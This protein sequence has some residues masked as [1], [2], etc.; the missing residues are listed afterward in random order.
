MNDPYKNEKYRPYM[1]GYFVNVD[2]STR[3]HRRPLYPPA[4]KSM[5][6]GEEDLKKIK[7]LTFRPLIMAYN[8]PRFVF[9]YH[10]AGG[11]LGHLMLAVCDSKTK[12]G[13]WLHNFDDIRMIYSDGVIRYE[14][15][16]TAYQD[17]IC[18]IE[19]APSADTI[20]LILRIKVS[21]DATGKTILAF[22]GGAS[23]FYTRKRYDMPEYIYDPIH[24]NKDTIEFNKNSFTLIRAFYP[25]DICMT[26]KYMAPN[27]LHDYT[28]KIR[29]DSQNFDFCGYGTYDEDPYSIYGS[30]RQTD[31]G[32]YKA[33]MG[34]FYQKLDNIKSEMYI[35][36]GMGSG[37]DGSKN[38]LEVSWKS[39]IKRNSDI[40]G[41]IRIKTP[42]Q[43]LDNAMHML[44]FCLEGL[45]GDEAVLHG[46]LSWRTGYLGWR[47]WYGVVCYG[48]E[49]RI[50]KCIDNFI[51]LGLVRNGDDKGAL[52]C[53]YE[54]EPMVYYNMNEVFTDQIRQYFEYTNDIEL[55]R[56]IL[57][58]LEGIVKW[59]NKRL[60]PQKEALYESCLNTWISDCH[61]YIE[62]Q[63]TQASAY[64]LNA[65]KL[66]AYISG[67]LNQDPEPYLDMVKNIYDSMQDVLWME[68]EGI[69]A[70][71]K[72]TIG[73]GMLHP[74]PELATIYH[75]AEFGAASQIQIDQMLNWADNNLL[76]EKTFNNGELY[77]SA[78]WFPN[79]ARSYTHSTYELAY[80]EELNYALTNYLG[81][82]NEDAYKLILGALC[83]I[84]SGPTAGGLPC[85]V[86][87]EGRQRRNDEFADAIS[88]FARTVYEGLFGIRPIKPDGII[89]LSP[90]FP[91]DWKCAHISSPHL[92]YTLNH[93]DGKLEIVWEAAYETIIKLDIPLRASNIISVMSD[94]MQTEYNVRPGVSCTWL[95]MNTKAQNN[96]TIQIRYVPKDQIRPEIINILDG[97][98]VC[99]DAPDNGMEY[100]LDPQK[101][102]YESKIDNSLMTGCIRTNQKNALIYTAGG[103][104]EAPYWIPNRISIKHNDE[105]AP[106][107]WVSDDLDIKYNSTWK[108][109]TIHDIYNASSPLEVL[110][111]IAASAIPPKLPYS[112]IGFEYWMTHIERYCINGP[113]PPVDDA[114]RIITGEDG[115]LHTTEGIPFYTSKYGKNMGIVTIVAQNPDKTTQLYPKSL[116]FNVDKKG[117]ELYL[118]I[119]GM[120]F[121][122]QS[123]VPNIEITLMYED[124]SSL[125]R[126][127]IN[128][129]GIGDC[130]GTWHGRYHDTQANGFVNIGGRYG[131][132]G[133]AH[134][135]DITKPVS[136]DTEA[137]IVR[138]PIRS[139]VILK[140]VTFEAAA[141]DVIF[142]IIGASI[143]S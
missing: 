61:W 83:G 76:K 128:P 35:R 116:S 22:Y 92:N 17:F 130:W 134:V 72:D 24:S 125:T 28:A 127:L 54:P 20:G 93:A 141:N 3:H 56:K 41:R 53:L 7:R 46:A 97:S 43:A 90:Q 29:V 2:D 70:E 113:Y 111:N 114:L 96:G 63:C 110:K 8:E 109:I 51:T 140:K 11:L 121:P 44:S 80:A 122:A 38:D 32:S 19:A 4:D 30:I 102:L 75:S 89:R 95:S 87:R 117:R 55:M 77:W 58:V 74:E 10:T 69:Y 131:P 25:D 88:M 60:K 18:I 52:S 107:I 137:H 99:F 16:D 106:D 112:Q 139:D 33:V 62:G 65:Y 1:N 26:E 126:Q 105:K 82:R 31:K 37:I 103:T 64:M 85:H 45:W 57:P 91:D 101:V 142:G 42:D 120:T 36:A 143:R 115:I 48:W 86:D 68:K 47:S 100:F 27:F 6:W 21:G 34:V 136:V 23:A 123:H 40:S 49:D 59:E 133:S 67:K 132:A 94:N 104:K 15:K 108:F 135:E 118:L 78:N 124:S 119:T 71:S 73:R 129:F 5:V 84:Y 9:D 14:I 39:A 81:A 50:K 138:I 79:E 12:S 13:K 98:D 66:L